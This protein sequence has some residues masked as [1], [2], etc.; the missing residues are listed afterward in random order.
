LG[1]AGVGGAYVAGIFPRRAANVNG[2]N[3]TTTTP[4]PDGTPGVAQSKPDMI[5]VPGGTFTMGRNDGTDLEKPEHE[6]TVEPFLMDKTEVTNGEFYEFVQATKYSPVPADWENGHPVA[7]REKMPVRYVNIADI[8]AFIKWRSDRDKTKYRLPTEEEWEFAARNGSKNDLY[9]WGD[10]FQSNC[11]V[12]DEDRNDPKPVGTHACPATW[13]FVDLIGNVMEWTSTPVSLYPG[14]VGE[15][16][17][18]DEP[19]FMVR[20][21]SA[22][23]KSTGKTAIT[24]TFRV[25]SPQSTRHPALGFRLARSE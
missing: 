16:K 2:V 6:V 14:S 3:G 8:T 11:A 22:M 17:P 13:G 25:D 15:I 21:G 24:S 1:I 18:S 5:S 10:K 23:Y 19:R 7:G 4:T 12:L 20:G 9:P